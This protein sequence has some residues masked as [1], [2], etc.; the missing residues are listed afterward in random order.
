M[1]TIADAWAL[2]REWSAAVARYWE[3][4]NQRLLVHQL[5]QVTCSDDEKTHDALPCKDCGAAL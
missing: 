5:G 3:K 2:I 4:W 1:T